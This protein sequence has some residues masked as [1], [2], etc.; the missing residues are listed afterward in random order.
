METRVKTTRSKT[1]EKSKK[2][3]KTGK[4]GAAK[5]HHGGLGFHPV[6]F[7]T[8]NRIVRDGW[9]TTCKICI[10]TL[11]T[12]TELTTYTGTSSGGESVRLLTD[13]AKSIIQKATSQGEYRTRTDKLKPPFMALSVDPDD[14]PLVCRF[15]PHSL[16]YILNSQSGARIAMTLQRLGSS[17]LD[18]GLLH[19]WLPLTTQQ[20][21]SSGVQPSKIR[22]LSS[23]ASIAR[24]RKRRW[25]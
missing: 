17:V 21:A 15:L 13:R 22:L 7:S 9:T 3:G 1:K 12:T 16:V 18:A 24:T 5:L 6:D 2:S 25:W 11:P 8:E 20:A 14:Y 23:V 19:A 10:F 4:R